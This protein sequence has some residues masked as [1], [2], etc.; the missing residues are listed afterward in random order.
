LD[1]LRSN[2]P[3]ETSIFVTIEGGVS[4]RGAKGEGAKGRERVLAEA[5]RGKALRRERGFSQRR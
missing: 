5:L 2:I 3:N 1:L 4:R